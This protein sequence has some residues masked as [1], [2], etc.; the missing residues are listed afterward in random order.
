M[1]D[2]KRCICDN[3]DFLNAEMTLRKLWCSHDYF[4]T[5]AKENWRL[6]PSGSAWW[7]EIGWG[8]RMPWGENLFWSNEGF[9]EL[10]QLGQ[11]GFCRTETLGTQIMSG[12]PPPSA[13]LSMIRSRK[14]RPLFDLDINYVPQSLHLLQAKGVEM[15]FGLIPFK[16]TSFMLGIIKGQICSSVAVI[17]ELI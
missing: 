10:E 16:Y 4:T 8:A 14:T 7:K 2:C 1:S 6:W 11:L 9:V 12:C 15:L 5:V 3:T 17:F 13:V